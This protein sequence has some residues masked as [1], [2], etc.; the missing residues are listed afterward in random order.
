MRCIAVRRAGQ[1]D[2]PGLELADRLV[3]TLSDLTL[4]DIDRLLGV[5]PE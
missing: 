4:A 2:A 5:E 3:D 1:P